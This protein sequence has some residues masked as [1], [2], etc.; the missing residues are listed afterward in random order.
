MNPLLTKRRHRAF[1]GWDLLVVIVT[2]ALLLVLLPVFTRARSKSSRISCA[3][4][5]KQVALAVR[6]WATDGGE[7]FPWTHSTNFGGSLEYVGTPDPLPHFRAISKDLGKPG[8][9]VCPDDKS[10]KKAADWTQFTNSIY[11]SYFL[12]FEAEETK[13]QTTLSGDR[14]ISTNGIAAI[15][16][17]LLTASDKLGWTTGV[18]PGYGN[19]AMADGSAQQV[20]APGLSN[21]FQATLLSTTQAAVRLVIPK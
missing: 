19:I 17:V 4:N 14:N 5:L 1:T 13:P 20:T 8:D 7:G 3:Y 11:L 9:L 2:V 6:M 18:H 16:L 21:P 12:C 15:G 10:R